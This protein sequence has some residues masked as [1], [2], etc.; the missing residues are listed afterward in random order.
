MSHKCHTIVAKLSHK[1]LDFS[2]KMCIIDGINNKEFY[3]E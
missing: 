1:K 3:Y 2:V